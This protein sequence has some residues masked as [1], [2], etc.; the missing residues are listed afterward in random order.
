[1]L[2][3]KRNRKA[4]QINQKQQQQ[5]TDAELM[6]HPI[7]ANSLKIGKIGKQDDVIDFENEKN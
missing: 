6:T 3:Q 2:K 7:I 5:R 4:R 1:M